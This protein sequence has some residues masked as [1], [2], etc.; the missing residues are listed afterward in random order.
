MPARSDSTAVRQLRQATRKYI[1][2][3]SS[4]YPE[5]GSRMG[6][7]E[8]DPLL[9]QNDA[10]THKAHIALCRSLH[11]EVERIVPDTLAPDDWLDRRGFLSLLRR[12]LLSQDSW[13]RWRNNPQGACDAAIDSVFH[14]IVRSEGRLAAALPAIESRLKKIPAFLDAAAR[15]LSRPV[16]LWTALTQKTCQGACEFLDDLEKDLT[17]ASDRPSRTA[18]ALRGAKR[19]FTDYATAAAR[20]AQAPKN[21]YAIGTRDFEYLIREHLGLDLT[22]AEARTLGF[23]LMERFQT[24]IERETRRLGYRQA[25]AALEEAREAWKPEGPLVEHYRRTTRDILARLRRMKLVSLPKGEA[26][27]VR[28]VPAFLRNHFPTAAYDA[29][30]PFARHHRGT[31]WVNDLGGNGPQALRERQQHFGLELTCIHE[32]YPGHHLQFVRQYAHSSPIRRLCE[33][34]IGYEGWTMWCE[35]F[36]V[37]EGLVDAPWARLQQLQDALWRACRIVIDCSL[38]DGSMTLRT[39]RDFLVKHVGFTPKRA[40]VDINWYSSSP[41]VPMSYLLGRLEVEKL[42]RFFTQREGWSLRQ[43]ND[44]LLSFG[45]LPP[46]WIFQAWVR[47]QAPTK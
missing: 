36:A 31:F 19:A 47:G 23:S 26:L 6:F 29:P 22:L 35:K 15:H 18:S 11:D 20:R 39:A 16:P 10:A 34:A 4:L 38:H 41:T 14:L 8:C 3:T 27:D 24:E 17:A 30:E 40:E 12:R 28:E 37:E 33:H 2:E 9:S 5:W 45:A 32:A 43:F 42:H 25:S 1:Q 44:W 13:Q 7:R 46:A 21:A